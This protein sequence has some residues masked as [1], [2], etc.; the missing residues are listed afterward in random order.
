M[1]RRGTLVSVAKRQ[2]VADV[3]GGSIG[4]DKTAL[5]VGLPSVVGE[6]KQI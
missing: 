2:T 6:R 5:A 3:P 4:D 1:I